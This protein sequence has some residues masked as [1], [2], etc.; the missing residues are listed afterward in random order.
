MLNIRENKAGHCDLCGIHMNGSYQILMNALDMKVIVLSGYDPFVRIYGRL[1]KQL[2]SGAGHLEQ[3]K[4]VVMADTR[5]WQLCSNCGS[6]IRNYSQDPNR[7]KR[8]A[9]GH[10]LLAKKLWESRGPNDDMKPITENLNKA[11][12]ID[13]EHAEAQYLQGSISTI[14]GSV[15]LVDGG[16][17]NLDMIAKV[18]V[19]AEEHLRMA[20]KLKPGHADAHAALAELLVF[21]AFL[22]E[23]LGV[24]ELPGNYGGELTQA[25]TYHWRRKG[26]SLLSERYPREPESELLL[27]LQLEP[28]HVKANFALGSLYLHSQGQF[29]G[30]NTYR[31]AIKH[32]N[33]VIEQ[34]PQ[35]AQAHYALGQL[36]NKQGEWQAAFEHLSLAVQYDPNNTAARQLRDQDKRKVD[37]KKWWQF[38]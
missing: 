1:P 37:G 17:Q 16:G 9:H 18:F 24:R 35:H 29:T 2:A 30:K 15:L 8:M 19:M 7:Q 26:F 3:W 4:G 6:D 12:T 23:L 32:L 27:A 33:V 31:L 10:Y 22:A 25:A 34:Q 36:Y 21:M 13:L 20:L 38:W 28:R 5:G 14:A 11:I